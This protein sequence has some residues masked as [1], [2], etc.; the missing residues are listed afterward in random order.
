[1]G[2]RRAAPRPFRFAQE[3]SGEPKEWHPV[4]R[5]TLRNY[6][7]LRVFRDLRRSKLPRLVW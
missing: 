4:V 5:D 7:L 6:R 1:M 2:E 3:A